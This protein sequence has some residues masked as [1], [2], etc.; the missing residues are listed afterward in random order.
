MMMSKPEEEKNS[1]KLVPPTPLKTQSAADS[2][3]DLERRLQLMSAAETKP[4]AT[5]KPAPAAVKPASTAAAATGGGKNALLVSAL[6]TDTS[7]RHKQENYSFCCFQSR[8][9]VMR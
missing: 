5:T 7:V 9:R 6:E 4:A 2:V 8:L 3:K 1:D